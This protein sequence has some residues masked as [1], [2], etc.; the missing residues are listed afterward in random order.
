MDESIALGKKKFPSSQFRID[1][2]AAVR[3][4]TDLLLYVLSK[5]DEEGSRGEE[6]STSQ[7]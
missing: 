7:Y 3:I 1:K 5:R 6:A 4:I 2:N